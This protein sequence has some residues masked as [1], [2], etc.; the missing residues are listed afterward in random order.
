DTHTSE[1]IMALLQALNEQGVTIVMVTHEEDI[2]EH[3][4]RV[5]RFRDGHL[6]SDEPVTGRRFLATEYLATHPAEG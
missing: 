4:T 1:E 2:A 3:G 5:V 6:E